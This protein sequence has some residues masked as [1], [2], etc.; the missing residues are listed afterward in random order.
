MS[1][2]QAVV[3][4]GA[5]IPHLPPVESSLLLARD[6]SG[7]IKATDKLRVPLDD[8]GVPDPEA[9]LKLLLSTV[10]HSYVWPSRNNVHHLAHPRSE[11]HKDGR[12]SIAY[13]YR[14]TASIMMDMATQL[15]NYGHEVGLPPPRPSEEVMAARVREQSQID[16]LFKIGRGAISSD[17]WKQEMVQRGTYAHRL[18][19]DYVDR[20][21][22]TPQDFYDYLEQ[23][24]DGVVGLMPD[25][26]ELYAMDLHDATRRLGV[27]AA[28]RSL[29]YRRDS[30]SSSLMFGS[31]IMDTWQ[32]FLLI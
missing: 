26:Q 13:K 20:Y 6:S 1:E 12:E 16:R 2:M 23:C 5:R 28:A 3:R 27:L 19:N 10:D 7:K 4:S 32:H 15:H 25:R 18:A 14:E 30:R 11:Y 17:R 22:P 8:Y 24:E 9:Y 29:D 31:D 21:A